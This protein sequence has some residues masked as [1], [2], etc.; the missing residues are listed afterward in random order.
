M[1]KF[2]IGDIVKFKGSQ[3]NIPNATYIS[4]YSYNLGFNREDIKHGTTCLGS[5]YMENKAK[6]I[7]INK[8]SKRYLITWTSA[9]EQKM[10]L[11]F[12]EN[13]IELVKSRSP[14]GIWA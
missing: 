12:P 3:S 14:I 11:S 1:D 10:Q 9:Q 5:N 4:G 6:I 2:K 13:D 8:E 7:K